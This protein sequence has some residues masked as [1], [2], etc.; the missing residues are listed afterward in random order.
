MVTIYMDDSES[1]ISVVWTQT[2]MVELRVI[3]TSDAVMSSVFALDGIFMMERRESEVSALV[4]ESGSLRTKPLGTISDPLCR[5]NYSSKVLEGYDHVVAQLKDPKPTGRLSILNGPPGVGK[6][7]LIRGLI[8]DIKE[9]N[10]HFILINPDMASRLTGPD[11]LS[12]FMDKNKRHVI[13]LEDGDVCL[14]KKARDSMSEIQAVLNMADGIIGQLL[15]FRIVCT[16]NVRTADLD[17]AIIRPGR[18]ARLVEVGPLSVDEA[19]MLYGSLGGVGASFEREATLAEIYARVRDPE[20]F[21]ATEAA[22][23]RHLGFASR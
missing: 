8:H 6:T 2:D 5:G 23:V 22:P 7:H 13:I 16:A 19:N 11:C 18:L 10:L 20:A 1:F 9:S 3:T 12:L 21:E 14:T 17:K 15:D 4:I